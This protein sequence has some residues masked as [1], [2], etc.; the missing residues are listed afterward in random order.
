MNTHQT[1]PGELLNRIARFGRLYLLDTVSSTNDYAFGLA[2]PGPRREQ[3]PAIVVARKQTKGRGRFRRHW[4]GDEESLLFS[5]L[6][7]LEKNISSPNSITQFAGL[8][9]CR[10]I[11]RLA[12]SALC[13]KS[14]P[15]L[16]W[17]NDLI[18]DGK[19]VAGILCEQRRNAVVVGIGI[20]VNQSLLP[21]NLPEASSLF[22]TFH[23][24]FDRMVLLEA[25]LTD[26][27]NCLDLLKKC[28]TTTLW[29]EIKNRSAIIHH[30][31][32][33]RTLFRKY[34]GTVI[35]IDDSGRIVLRTDSGK[36]AIFNAGQVKQLR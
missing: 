35:D 21:E 32:E 19:K 27:F 11:E 34:I 15:L 25:F 10:A 7:F 23:Q 36:L 30:R 6:L 17:P 8:A 20:N 26:F 18:V 28:E 12:G 13:E 24:K 22:L 33:I 14:P 1:I 29:A 5:I 16:R 3:E 4:F 31:V 2:T 9:L